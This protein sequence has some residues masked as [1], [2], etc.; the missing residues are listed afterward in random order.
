MRKVKPYFR[1]MLVS[2]L[3]FGLFFGMGS[4]LSN[5]F[6]KAQTVANTDEEETVAEKKQDGERTNILMLG[7][8]ARPGETHSRSDTMMLVSIDPKLDKMAVISIPRD[9]KVKVKGSSNEKICTANYV[10]GPKYAKQ[11]VEE[12]LDT[13]IDYYVEMDFKAFTKVVDTLGG[14]TINVP[15]RMYK[16]YEGIDLKSG[17]QKLNGKQA[18][19]YVRFRD[20]EFGD[21]QRTAQQQEFIKIL[22]DQALQAKTIPKIPKLFKEVK[23]YLDTDLGFTDMVRMASWAPGFTKESILTQTL[24]GY[25]YDVRDE[26]GNLAE[27]YWVA[28]KKVATELIDKMFAGEAI[29]AAIQQSP[30]PVSTPPKKT[31]TEDESSENTVTPEEQTRIN[32]ERSK[33]PSPGHEHRG[34][35]AEVNAPVPDTTQNNNGSGSGTGPEGYI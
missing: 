31:K 11:L 19:G 24:P 9:T 30:Y 2:G 7:V 21:I 23:P 29:A 15:Q 35:H 5:F 17:T 22:A 10:G 12:L 32:E 28:D 13:K 26:D 16:P 1:F 34:N 20:Y 18:L 3:I 33:L 27:S 8:D 14:V 4:G 6:H 25:F